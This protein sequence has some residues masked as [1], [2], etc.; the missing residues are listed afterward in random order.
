MRSK[1]ALLN[2][3]STLLLQLI[4]LT[5][6]FI[7][8]RLYIQTYG[9]EIN[10]MISSIRQFIVYLSLI[11]GG[12]AA[13]S[14]AAL[15]KP[16]AQKDY[17]RINSILSATKS[18]YS[19]IGMI[20]LMLVFGI[21]LLYSYLV[22]QEVSFFLSFLMVIILGISAFIEYFILGKYKIILTAY[23]KSY[24]LSKIQMQATIINTI[25]I[26]ILIL[27][28][29]HI[30]IVQMTATLIYLLRVLIIKKYIKKNHSNLNFNEKADFK[31]IDQKW[32]A[33]I[34]QLSSLVVF[35]SPLIILTVLTNLLEVS[36]FSIYLLIFSGIQM[37]ISAFSSGLIAGFGD[38]IS[39]NNNKIL[40]KTFEDVEFLYFIILFIIYTSAFILVMPFIGVYTESFTDADYFRPWVATLFILVGV[41]NNIRVPANILVTASGHFKETKYRALL[42]AL[43]NIVCSVIFTI[44][45]GMI[46]VLLG[47]LCSFSYRSIDFILYGSKYILKM[48]SS[49]TFIKILFNF[50][51]SMFSVFFIKSFLTVEAESIL[52]W[53]LWACIILF[54]V[55]FFMVIANLIFYTENVKKIVIRLMHLKSNFKR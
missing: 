5:A 35:N 15:Y 40:T 25:L 41:A 13:A 9:S 51:M 44:Q 7:L 4:I 30:L 33:L 24:I 23:Q 10:G 34:H 19:K 14:L 49:G 46:G 27:L 52:E 32:Q 37:L 45:F 20:F 17:Y 48:S 28:D 50:G 38:L 22:S 42:E 11:E 54:I 36:V 6:G 39:T 53:V 18:F 43:I 12:V 26:S 31:A 47:S 29:F 16:I 8:P 55:S 3:S 1:S 21:S 2:V